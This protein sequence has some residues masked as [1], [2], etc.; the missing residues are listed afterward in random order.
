MKSGSHSQQ[1]KWS[2][3]AQEKGGQLISRHRINK[4]IIQEECPLELVSFHFVWENTTT[5]IC[6]E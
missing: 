4:L 3:G 2:M 5:T 1:L 6:I